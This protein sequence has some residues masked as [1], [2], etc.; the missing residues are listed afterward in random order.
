MSVVVCCYPGSSAHRRAAWFAGS[1]LMVFL[2]LV[3]V[4]SA[5]LA[6]CF[7][8]CSSNDDCE[9]FG[10]FCAANTAGACR[11]CAQYVHQI[12]EYSAACADPATASF[13]MPDAFS[14]LGLVEGT[15]GAADADA[16]CEA[17]SDS[18]GSQ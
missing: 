11:M 14:D 16:M 4:A 9:G 7:Q 1:A 10:T 8:S 17:C 12:D 18:E 3:M 13:I 2:Q 5:S 6:I 15:D